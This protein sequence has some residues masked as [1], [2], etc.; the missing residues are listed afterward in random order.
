VTNIAERHVIDFTI[1]R[2]TSM[3]RSQKMGEWTM[4]YNKINTTN[5]TVMKWFKLKDG[6][7]IFVDHNNER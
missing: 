7:V 3:L 5:K 1:Q 4:K 2:I 6:N